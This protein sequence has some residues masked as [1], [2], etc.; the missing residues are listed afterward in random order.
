LATL[1][2]PSLEFSLGALFLEYIFAECWFGPTVAGLQAAAPPSAQG[3]TAGV[4]SCLTLIGNFA[5][6]FIG[7]AIQSGGYELPSLL[8][9]SVPVLY[10]GSALVFVAAGQAIQEK[11]EK[12]G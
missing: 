3:L 4:F 6:F 9:Y 11:S 2:A 1:N 10:A 12:G 7:L 5:P 8:S